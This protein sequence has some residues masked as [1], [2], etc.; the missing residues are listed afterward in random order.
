MQYPASGVWGKQW[1]VK[2][3]TRAW[4]G[5]SFKHGHQYASQCAS[6]P[7][8]LVGVVQRHSE[9]GRQEAEF[10]GKSKGARHWNGVDSLEIQLSEPS[11]APL[12]NE[13]SHVKVLVVGHWD[14]PRQLFGE[15]ASDLGEARGIRQPV[16]PDAVDVGPADIS[17]ARIDQGG[18]LLPHRRSIVFSHN[19][20]DFDDVAHMG[21]QTGRLEVEAGVGGHGATVLAG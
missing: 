18:P 17:G 19:Y 4:V 1:R 2:D 12:L 6:V 5:T 20:C 16:G 10:P 9:C 21:I 3:R 8:G 14:V 7:Q 15:V 13:E 11:A